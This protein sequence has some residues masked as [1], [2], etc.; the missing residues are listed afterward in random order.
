MA[1]NRHPPPEQ[2]CYE[3]ERMRA[4]QD[5]IDRSMNKKL[6]RIMLLDAAELSSGKLEELEACIKEKR[7]KSKG[8][9]P[10]R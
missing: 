7:K 5:A 4:S 1:S 3:K 2:T 8:G 10:K 9:K 6:G